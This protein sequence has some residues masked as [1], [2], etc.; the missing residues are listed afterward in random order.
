MWR[1]SIIPNKNVTSHLTACTNKII[2]YNKKVILNI[3]CLDYHFKTK[4]ISK[5]G[6]NFKKR[7]Q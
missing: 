7:I 3:P 4:L 5:I 2:H 1:T 6:V